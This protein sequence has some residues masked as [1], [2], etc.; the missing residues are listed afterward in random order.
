M[1]TNVIIQTNSTTA[2]I[3]MQYHEYCFVYSTRLLSFSI[4]THLLFQVAHFLPSTFLHT[5]HP[6]WAITS[7]GKS[8]STKSAHRIHYLMLLF[9]F[10][11]RNDQYQFFC[12]VFP[13]GYAGYAKIKK[14]WQLK[15]GN[16]EA[17]I[18]HWSREEF[19]CYFPSTVAAKQQNQHLRFLIH[20][21][22]FCGDQSARGS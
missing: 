3:Q 17:F 1:S 4:V 6:C 20:Q 2:V 19:R 13:S 7:R 9:A 18:G 11:D 15:T 10:A 12:R 14:L 21:F 8:H 5:Q 22:L 16:W